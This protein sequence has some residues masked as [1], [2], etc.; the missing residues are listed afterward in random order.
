VNVHRKGLPRKWSLL[1]SGV[2]AL[3]VI[4]GSAIVCAKVYNE[5]ARQKVLGR[6]IYD[7]KANGRELIQQALRDA[8]EQRKRVLV[9][10]GGN[11]CKWCLTLDDVMQSD[12]EISRLLDDKFIFVH[13]DVTSNEALDK[14]WGWPSHMGVPALVV[15]DPNGT[16]KTT[17]DGTELR[18]VRGLMY[19]D[20]VAILATLNDNL[21]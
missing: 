9:M 16:A 4:G 15:L 3:L 5:V 8:T 19:Y 2:V 11:W 12:R 20:P 13:L 6:R 7:E 18:G 10:L 14:E 21:P 17:V 1:Q